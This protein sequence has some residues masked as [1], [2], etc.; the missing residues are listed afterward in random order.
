MERGGDGE[1]RGLGGETPLH[2][3]AKYSS[4]FALEILLKLGANPNQ[5]S[6][7]DFILLFIYLIDLFI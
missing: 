7:F 4:S 5:L 3:A 6:S 2:I 1:G